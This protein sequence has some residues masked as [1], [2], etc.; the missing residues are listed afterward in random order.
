[1]AEAETAVMELR[2]K[3]RWPPL[4]ARKRQ[5]TVIPRVLEEA[6]ALPTLGFLPPGL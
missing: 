5:G 4:Q 2:A 6:M 3:C 1:M